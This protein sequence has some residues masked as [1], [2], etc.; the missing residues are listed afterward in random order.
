MDSLETPVKFL[1]Y[2]ITVFGVI[3]GILQKNKS[4]MII[5]GIIFLVIISA[6]FF[7]IFVLIPSM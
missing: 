1:G 5:S 2:I 4:V 3:L 6:V 7:L